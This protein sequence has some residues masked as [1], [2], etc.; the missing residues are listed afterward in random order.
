MSVTIDTMRD[1]LMIIL[2]CVLVWVIQGEMPKTE[3]YDEPYETTAVAIPFP[4]MV[5]PTVVTVTQHDNEEQVDE[6]QVDEEQVDESPLQVHEE[7]VDES[8]VHEE[9]VHEEQVNESLIHYY[10]EPHKNDKTPDIDIPYQYHDMYDYNET[11]IHFIDNPYVVYN[12]PK[13]TLVKPV[14]RFS[15]QQ[16]DCAID[17]IEN[18]KSVNMVC[19]LAPM[20]SGK[21][22]TFLLVGFEKLRRNHV[23]RVIIFSGSAEKRLKEQTIANIENTL[24]NE[25]VNFLIEN[26]GFAIQDAIDIAAVLRLKFYVVWGPD[27]PKYNGPT[28]RNLFI[29]DESHFAQNKNNRPNQFLSRY[30]INPSGSSIEQMKSDENMLLSVSATPFS[31]ASDIMI[32]NQSKS[33]VRLKPGNNYRGVKEAYN[34]RQIVFYKNI[35]EALQTALKKYAGMNKISIIREKGTSRRQKEKLIQM[36]QDMGYKIEYYDSSDT[37]TVNSLDI[38]GREPTQPTL[39]FVKD[40]CRMGEV[41]NKQWVGFGFETVVNP[42]EDVILQGLL[43]RLLMGYDVNLDVTVYINANFLK[44]VDDPT[45]PFD[46]YDRLING[47]NIIPTTGQNLA[48]AK[49]ERKHRGDKHLIVPVVIPEYVIKNS[50]GEHY[51]TG[52]IGYLENEG[53][54]LHYN[55]NQQMIEGIQMLKSIRDLSS[56]SEYKITKRDMKSKT[57]TGVLEKIN[58]SITTKRPSSLGSSAG[59]DIHGKSMN[60]WSNGSDYYLEFR[61]SSEPAVYKGLVF[62]PITQTTG[63]EMFC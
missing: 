47:E 34:N 38:L 19:L 60:L 14:K 63:K 25:C 1:I 17:I 48:R 28:T 10:Y 33:L 52:L 9:Q 45:Q 16:I 7:Q 44:N 23:D 53:K 8:Q 55:T 22:G 39:I 59:I 57:Y 61:T 36:A 49:R 4:V 29:H 12:T 24:K 56:R 43:A 5:E 21:S 27:L 11:D 3:K 20:Q 40:R 62:Q 2:M 15:R 46:R 42:R 51:L 35:Y 30:G 50:D 26:K 31:E 58:K 54:H 41:L 32:L 18:H 6:S 13:K 37:S